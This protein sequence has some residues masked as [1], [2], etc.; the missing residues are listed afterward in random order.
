MKNKKIVRNYKDRLFI[1]LFGNEKNRQFALELYNAVNHSSYTDPNE[2][3]FETLNDIICIGRKNDVAF[4][5]HK[6]INL[7]EHQSTYNPNMPLRQLFYIN[8]LF[9]KC[10]LAQP[11]SLYG[12]HRIE[13]PTP[14]FIVFYNGE[15]R[16]E[17]EKDMHLSFSYENSKD[18]QLELIVRLVDINYGSNEPILK[19]CKPLYEYSWLINRVRQNKASGESTEDAVGHAIMEMPNNFEIHNLV[20]Q[21]MMEVKKMVVFDLNDENERRKYDA[22]LFNDGKEEG[23]AEGRAEERE[24][25]AKIIKE[26]LSEMGLSEEEIEKKVQKI[27]TAG[28]SDIKPTTM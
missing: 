28:S 26:I 16:K 18:P 24:N 12:S 9:E 27:K 8:D 2:I 20:Q 21:N 14:K 17:E 23:R 19:E 22:D 4:M 15:R 10:V 6:E 7:Y 11:H 3:E 25:S 5:I 1:Y 13:L